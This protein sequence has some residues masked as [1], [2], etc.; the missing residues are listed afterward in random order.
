MTFITWKAPLGPGTGLYG[1]LGTGG[2]AEVQQ[3][4]LNLRKSLAF[5]RPK[6]DANN[7]DSEALIS[8][9]QGTAGALDGEYRNLTSEILV[10]CSESTRHHPNIITIEAVCWDFDERTG[11]AWPILVFDK[12]EERDLETFMKTPRGRHLDNRKRLQLCQDIAIAMI[13]LHRYGMVVVS[14]GCNTSDSL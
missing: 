2:T 3:R 5:K 13:A 14:D 4:T 7:E 6:I 12:A 11:V 1:S 10:L 9:T 8:S